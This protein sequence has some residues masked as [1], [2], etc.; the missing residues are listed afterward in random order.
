M[1]ADARVPP[2]CCHCRLGSPPVPVA[3]QLASLGALELPTWV[4]D[5]QIKQIGWNQIVLSNNLL[6]QRNDLLRVVGLAHCLFQAFPHLT[7]RLWHRTP[8]LE[9]LDRIIEG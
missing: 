2:R 5:G 8:L 7:Q 9:R 6:Q 3:V 4:L 1:L